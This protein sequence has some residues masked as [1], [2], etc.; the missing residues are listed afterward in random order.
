MNRNQVKQEIKKCSVDELKQWRNHAVKC[1]N[2]FLKYR[3]EFEL[4]ECNFVISHIDNRLDQLS[5]T[6]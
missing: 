3:D 2:Y 1:L 5:E 4:E 6:D